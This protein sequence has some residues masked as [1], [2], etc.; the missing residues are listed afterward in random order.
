MKRIRLG[1]SSC[2]L[3]YHTRYDSGHRLDPLL[4]ETLGKYVEFVPVCPEVELGLGVPRE[5]M[6][7]VGDPESARL[8]TVKTGRDVTR[9]MT[10]WGLTRVRELEKESLSGFIFKSRSPSCGLEQ[11]KIYGRPGGIAIRKGVGLFAR[12]FIRHFPLVP[13]I[14]EERLHDAAL[15]EDF[16][17]R[18]F[19]FDRRNPPVKRQIALLRKKLLAW[20]ETQRRDLPWR[21][22]ATSYRIWIS[23]VMLQQTQ[24][25]TVI[26]Y[27][28]RF[29]KRFPDIRSLAEAELEEVLKAW[30][31]LGYYARAR[32]LHRAAG[33]IAARHGGKLPD[34]L[35]DLLALPGIGAYSAGAILSLAFGRAVPAVDGNVKR[36][37]A[38]LYGIESPLSDKDTHGR[39]VRLAEALVP[40]KRPGDFNQALM[41]LGATVCT[42]TAARCT[43][44]P[45]KSL[46][47]ACRE[48]SQS[49]IPAAV[50]RKALPERNATAGWIQQPGNRFLIVQRPRE[51][52]LGGLWK[53]P[54][55]FGSEGETIEAALKRTVREE[56]GLRI[57]SMEPIAA[58]QHTFT[59]FRMTLHGFT[60][61]VSKKPRPS[62][63]TGVKWITPSEMTGY[64]F[65]KAD[66][67]LIKKI[68]QILLS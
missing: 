24:V 19:A 15:R 44:C 61:T 18:L 66:R 32:N 47:T 14:D 23:E 63:G 26:P 37:L 64:S 12:G 25:E 33:V 55:G 58:V 34:T 35:H 42:P 10:A 27:Y 59:H 60:C 41:D 45:V 17:G 53:L 20:Y 56:T 36:V 1:V 38:R 28:R 46:C 57:G 6:R 11:V 39:I 7:L 48:G 30:E 50:K 9:R 3:G 54:G 13:V 49:R 29:L 43:I 62:V 52:L 67:E 40:A 65:G 21:E 2:L 8:I 5:P 51:G 31:N 22:G 4:L 16:I 68:I